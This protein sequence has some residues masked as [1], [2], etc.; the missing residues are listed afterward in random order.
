MK[1]DEIVEW[2][3]SLERPV[4]GSVPMEYTTQLRLKLA[5]LMQSFYPKLS[6]CE[7]CKWPWS[8]AAAH[9]TKIGPSS[10]VSCLCEICWDVLGDVKRR[11][12]Y[13]KKRWNGAWQNVE[14]RD[15]ELGLEREPQ[16]QVSYSY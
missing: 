11:L 6:T 12:P 2:W 1:L 14:W 10:E 5:P 8:L 13:Y 7:R 9:Y 4:G 16:Y 15:I 3:N